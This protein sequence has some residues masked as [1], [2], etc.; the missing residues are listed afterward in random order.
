MRSLSRSFSAGEITP[1]LF[2]RIDLSSFQTGLSTCRNFISLP[3]GPVANRPG[4]EF[5]LEVKDSSKRTRLIPFTYSTTQTMVLEFGEHYV[6]FHTDGGTLLLAGVPYEV[7]TPYAEADLFGI[8]FVQS[9]DVLTLVHTGYAPRELRRLGT[10]SWTL[11]TIDFGI[12]QPY[13]G[14]LVDAIA[15]TLN[16]PVRL[17]PPKFLTIG[18]IVTPGPNNMN[19]AVTAIGDDVRQESAPCFATFAGVDNTMPISMNYGAVGGARGYRVY[20]DN[21]T[22]TYLLIAE[23]SALTITDNRN[24]DS[25]IQP[26]GPGSITP[27]TETNYYVLTSIGPD[28]Q[29][30]IQSLEVNALNDLT[31]PSAANIVYPTASTGLFPWV[32]FNVYKKKGGQYG[33][34][35]SGAPGETV[36]DDNIEPDMTHQPPVVNNPFDTSGNWPQAASYF[37]QRRLF[38]GTINKPQNL[39]ASRTGTESNM[40]SNFVVRN[41]DAISFRIASREANT[42]RHIVPLGEVILLTSSGEWRL[43]SSDGGPITP[44]NVSVR[45]QSYIGASNV[46]PVTTSG[47]MLYAAARGGNIREIVYSLSQNGAVGYNNTDLCLLAPHLFNFNTITDLAFAKAPYP[48]LWAISSNGNLLGLSYVPEQKVAG[49]HRHDTDGL[50]E[51]CAVVSENNED[52]LYVIVNRTINGSSRRY[53]ERLH[54]RKFATLQDAFFVD[55]G[56]TY[57]GGSATT[58]SGLGHLEGKTV[59]VL[60][61]GAVFPRKV[62]TGGAITLE[63]AVTLAHIGL[64]ITAD[65][66]TLPLSSEQ[67]EAFAQGRPKNISKVYIRVYRSSGIFAGPNAGQ[68]KAY[69]QR[70]TEPYDSPPA[71]IDSSEIEIVIPPNWGPDAQVLIRQSDPLPLTVLSLTLDGTVGG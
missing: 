34:I 14:G 31:Y 62:V 58:I 2:G 59:S 64:P 1:E 22:G 3:H 35:G 67:I 56:L 9:A 66:Q 36:K 23:T 37:E 19:Y 53:V 57:N 47:S 11:T 28:G 65:M 24:A 16:F 39:W 15:V 21:G 70:K 69:K 44:S 45:A 61:N 20:R 60:G 42:I 4:T 46:Q 40:T 49:W 13:F 43:T 7:V 51:S 63:K 38:A 68:L 55:C 26:G 29:E 17:S 71:L 25:P 5:V 10:T 27:N 12:T 30:S 8:H 32:R 33:F 50:F 41:D 52:M 18:T 6:R 54:T 48:I